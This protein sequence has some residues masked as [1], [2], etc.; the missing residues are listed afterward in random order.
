MNNN[1]DIQKNVRALL[2]GEKKFVIASD[3]D[4]EKTK[5]AMFFMAHAH[6]TLT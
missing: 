2:T 3:D 6:D 5:R 1:G 4:A